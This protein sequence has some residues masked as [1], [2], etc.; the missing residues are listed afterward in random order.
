MKDLDFKPEEYADRLRR[1]RAML[2][3]NAVDAMVIQDPASIFWLTG[4]RGKAYQ[5]YQALILRVDESP[6]TLITRTSDVDEALYTSIVDDIRGWRPEAGNDP[7]DILKDVLQLGRSGLKR[8]GFD[9]PLFYLSTSHYQ[10][11]TALLADTR[12]SNLTGLLEVLRQGR[13]AAEILYTLRASE[14]NDAGVRAGTDNLEVGRSELQVAGVMH[15]AMMSAGGQS[16]ASPMNFASGYRASFSHGFPT[17]KRIEK[18]DLIQTEWGA[19]YRGY[20]CTIGRMWSMGKPTERVAELYKVIRAASDAIIDMTKPGV[21]MCDLEKAAIK[22]VRPELRGF[23][24]HK[25]GYLVK[26][27]FPPAWGNYPALAPNES[28]VLEPGMMFSVEPPL[29]IPGEKLG[30]RLIDN[31]L[32]TE[33]GHQLMSKTPREL[34]VI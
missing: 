3:E 14:I 4:W 15:M 6:L 23:V 34:V 29:F 5:S 27:G 32:V 26:F 12:S 11:L 7:I 31:V 33:T 21:R 18:G 25:V 8:V 19:N 1:A 10:K 16:P 24:T 28:T 13:S 2:V 30:L 22:E 9:L 17:E 20:H